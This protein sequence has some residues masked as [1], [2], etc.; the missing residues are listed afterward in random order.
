[1]HSTL[2]VTT[3]LLA[4]RI[5][6]ADDQVKTTYTITDLGTLG[7]NNSIPYW[8]TNSGDVVGVSDTGRFDNFGFPIDHAF[9]W[10][11]GSMRDLGTLGGDNGSANGANDER[12]V[13]GGADVA[14]GV[15]SHAWLWDKG[16]ITD[17][18]ERPEWIQLRPVGQRQAASGR[19]VNYRGRKF[20]R[21]PLGRWRYD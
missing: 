11:N 10:S 21:R 19:G 8:I 2:V 4:G 1:M 3:L 12:A 14:G 20:S 9:V 18:A 13:V 6:W 7:G 5:C 16:A 17:L 15:T